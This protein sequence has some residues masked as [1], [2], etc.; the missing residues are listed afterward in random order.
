MKTGAE[1]V[2]KTTKAIQENNYPH[3]SQ[4]SLIAANEIIK[5]APKIFKD[6]CRINWTNN[7]YQIYNFIRG[8]SPYPGAFSYIVNGENE[9]FQVKIFK[10][11]PKICQHSFRAGEI[12]IIGKDGFD[13]WVNDGKISI[14]ELQIEGKKRMQTKDFLN[15]FHLTEKWRME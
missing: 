11:T 7:A 3:I 4:S 13:V 5:P 2:V 1:L 10:S 6:D 15:G 12:E 9:R 8:L 14:D